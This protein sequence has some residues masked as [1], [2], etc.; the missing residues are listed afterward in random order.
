MDDD[1]HW[2]VYYTEDQWGRIM[3]SFLTSCG[4]D[5]SMG[6]TTPVENGMNF[7]SCCGGRLVTDEELNNAQKH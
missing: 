3:N 7:C 1:C 5:V 2:H 6:F 4:R